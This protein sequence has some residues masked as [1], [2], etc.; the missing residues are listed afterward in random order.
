M[1]LGAVPPDPYVLPCP[2]FKI[3]KVSVKAL[4]FGVLFW[5]SANSG[6]RS[7]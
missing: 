3:T 6:E 4:C 5:A 7:I 1:G 2:I